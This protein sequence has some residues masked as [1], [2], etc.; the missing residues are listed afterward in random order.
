MKVN[1]SVVQEV[2]QQI[3]EIL[4]SKIPNKA[5][6][7]KLA[8]LLTSITKVYGQIVKNIDYSNNLSSVER[9]SKAAEIVMADS[10]WESRTFVMKAWTKL[11]NKI[12]KENE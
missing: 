1:R 8:D 7:D 5:K 11:N 12:K 9:I 2:E 4:D 6:R 10:V 3:A